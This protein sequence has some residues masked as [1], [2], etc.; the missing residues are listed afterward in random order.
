[1][2]NAQDLLSI[3]GGAGAGANRPSR[4]GGATGGAASNGSE[5]SILHF[6]AGKMNTSEKPNGKYMVEP[7]TRRG[8]LHVVWTTTSATAGTATAAAGG[9]N[10]AG[11]L[12]MEWKDRRTKTTVNTI[13]IFSEDDAT[14]ERVETGKESDRVYLLQCGNDADSRHFFW[15]QD[16]DTEPD[17]DLCAKVNLYMSD[18]SAAAEAAGTST[19]AAGTATET[20]AAGTGSGMDNDELLRIM[21]GALGGAGGA[22]GEAPEADRAL[23]APDDSGGQQ[24]DAL[25]NIL[26]NLGM[27]PPNSSATPAVGNAAA[28]SAS[29]GEAG[30]GGLTLADLQGAMA[31]LAT[32]SP[33]SESSTSIGPP[34]SELVSTDIIEESGI[35]SDPSTVARLVALLPEGQRTE[36][37]LRENIH[38]PQVAQCLQRLTA[39]LAEGPESFNS[40]IANFQLN[41]SDGAQSGNPIEQF[42]HCL[43]KDVERKEGVKKIDKDRTD[44]AGGEEGEKKE[45]EEVGGGKDGG[46]GEDVKMDES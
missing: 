13:S 30:A 3:L 33:P 9:A 5:T 8:E 35:L 44:N 25:G 40:I 18:H 15:M 31:G 29:T 32:A 16:K 20:S 34:L 14:F 10:G 17:D 39:A 38:S 45:D 21:Q 12:K 23:T 7:D 22:G 2:S 36:S 26:E 43:L 37:Q 1:M 6:K 4:A 19:A 28:N 11:H 27:P 46:D 42:L 24:V 41:P